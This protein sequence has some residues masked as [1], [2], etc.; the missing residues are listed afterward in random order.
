MKLY[1]IIG[2]AIIAFLGWHGY[3]AKQ[4]KVT[5]AELATANQTIKAH[6]KTLETERNDRR[7]ADAT[8]DRL[9]KALDDSR[10]QPPIVGVRCR[11]S[12]N[13]SAESGSPIPAHAAAPGA[14]QGL[15]ARDSVGSEPNGP[16]IDVSAGLDWY[17][18]RCS[19]QAI[20]QA[21]LQEFERARTH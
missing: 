19:E 21:A 14:G 16:E 17:A 7:I 20:E 5:K 9:N 18:S 1:L 2:V 4:L 10:K 11:T 12:R 15:P 6:E 13:V 8:I 3:V